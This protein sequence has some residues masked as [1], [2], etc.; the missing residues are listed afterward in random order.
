MDDTKELANLLVIRV[1]TEAAMLSVPG[2]AQEHRRLAAQLLDDAEQR[3]TS[4]R[5]RAEIESVRRVLAEAAH[6]QERP[7]DR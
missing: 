3:T 2:Q 1:T 6:E 4:S 7:A 5:V